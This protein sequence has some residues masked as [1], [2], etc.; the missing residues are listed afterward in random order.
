MQ[1]SGHVEGLGQRSTLGVVVP[2]ATSGQDECLTAR[3]MSHVCTWVRHGSLPRGRAVMGAGG[4]GS[5]RDVWG[6]DSAAG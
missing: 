2:R 1:R 6:G 4:G 5:D 3:L